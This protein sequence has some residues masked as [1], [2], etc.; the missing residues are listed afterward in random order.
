MPNEWEVED[1]LIG[2]SE[3]EVPKIEFDRRQKR[4]QRDQ[5]KIDSRDYTCRFVVDEFVVFY[6]K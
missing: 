3:T 2:Q 1:P 6:L 5:D 4:H